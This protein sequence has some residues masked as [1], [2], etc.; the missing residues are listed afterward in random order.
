MYRMKNVAE[1]LI[2]LKKIDKLQ[3]QDIDYLIDS[4]PKDINEDNEILLI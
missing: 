4:N 1:K 2:I 3:C